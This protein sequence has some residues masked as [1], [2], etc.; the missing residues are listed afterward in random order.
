MSLLRKI[1]PL[2][3]SSQK[4]LNLLH[5]I[6]FIFIFCIWKPVRKS[7][8]SLFFFLFFSIYKLQ[9]PLCP[10]QISSELGIAR[11]SGKHTTLVTTHKNKFIFNASWFIMNNSLF[12]ILHPSQNDF[13]QHSGI[14]HSP[15]PRC[16]L[17]D[18]ARYDSS[19]QS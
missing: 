2:A 8:L 5:Y 13:H 3:F 10:K 19:I 9:W 6:P 7:I 15:C 12:G 16:T 1:F 14:L 4:L 18:K 17:L 11:F